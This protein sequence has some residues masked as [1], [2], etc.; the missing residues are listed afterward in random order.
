[1]TF[2]ASMLCPSVGTDPVVQNKAKTPT[3]LTA[4][5]LH[6]VVLQNFMSK[7]LLR[8]GWRTIF[9]LCD[10]N[11]IVNFYIA[12]CRNFKTSFKAP[13]FQ[14]QTVSFDS[15]KNNLTDFDFYLDLIAKTARGKCIQLMASF[16]NLLLGNA[17]FISARSMVTRDILVRYHLK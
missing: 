12:I 11:T 7:F 13:V 5:P 10:E 17:V 1:V 8:F 2:K 3:I 14:L 9:M 16:I 15:R 4:S 6:Y